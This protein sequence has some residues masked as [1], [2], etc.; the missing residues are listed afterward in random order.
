MLA[1]KSSEPNY[2]LI[3][4]EGN[5]EIREYPILL[6]AEVRV[7]GE[8]Y[9]A[10]NMGFRILA[11]YIFGN[12]K[13]DKKIAMT[14]PVSQVREDNVWVI[15][16]VMPA[17][18]TLQT[19]PDPNNKKISLVE[20]K[21]KKFIV[22]RF[23]GANTESNLTTHQSKLLSYMSKHQLKSLN[24]PIFAFYNPPWILPLFRRNEIMIETDF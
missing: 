2:R 22:I 4:K 14:A 23:R 21:N 15:R 18:F 19:L 8:R 24:H 12:N 11:D 6:I 10:L 20:I 16:F 3:K 5:I 1:Y 13:A 9:V 17:D 7:E